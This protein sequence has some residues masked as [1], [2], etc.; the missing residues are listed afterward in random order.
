MLWSG[1]HLAGHRGPDDWGFVNLAPARL[2]GTR[3]RR[4]RYLE[5]SDRL[6]DYRVGLGCRRLSILDLSESGRQPMNLSGT[7]LW[8]VF[9]GEIYNYIE[10]RAELGAGYRFKTNSDTETL[11]A[12]Y[13]A[14]G[15]ACLQKLNGMFAF[16]IWDGLRRRLFLARDRFGEKPLYY[17]HRNGQFVF[18]SELKQIFNDPKF[19]RDVDETALADFMFLSVQDHDER[20][21]F[22]YAKQLRPAHFLE[23]ELDAGKLQRPQCYWRPEVADDLDTSCDERFQKRLPELL[24][25][26]VRLRLRSDVPAGVCLSGGLDSAVIC[27]VAASQLTSSTSLSAYTMTF[28]GHPEDE[29]SEAASAAEHFGIH[30]IELSLTGGTIWNQL[31]DFV[32]YQDG[33]AG[34]ASIFASWQ[35][36]IS[37][38]AHGTKV[39]LSGQGSDELFAGY[40]KFYFFWLETLLARGLLLRFG[41]A[42]A[43]Y[44]FRNGLSKWSYADGRKYLPPFLR[45]P[46]MSLWDFSDWDF[47][48]SATKGMDLGKGESLNVRLWKDLSELSL[49]CLLHWEDRNSMAAGTEARMPFLDHRLVE[50]VL[51]TSAHTKLKSGY[52]KS[53]LRHTMSGSLPVDLCWRTKKNGFDTPAK[54]WFKNDLAQQTEQTLLEKHSPLAEFFDMARLYGH[55]KS[56]RSGNGSLGL[57]ACD[58]FKIVTTGIWLKQVQTQ[59]AISEPALAVR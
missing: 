52:T 51:A 3:H 14:W 46:A 35:V 13:D 5:Q 20:T 41:A 15:P 47:R 48:R 38:R 23:F 45:R 30:N 53:S 9:N 57:T 8:I 34:G 4:W 24:Y 28:L 54:H 2:V 32:Y 36:F 19:P 43:S 55:F 26:S 56:F 17:F 31:N 22:Q 27:A 59:T 42:A 50:L 21:F 18:A 16:A 40:N 10:L 11:L 39:L 33:P 12:A 37:A 7:D 49:P 58:W 25:D 44:F 6:G 29:S 1:T